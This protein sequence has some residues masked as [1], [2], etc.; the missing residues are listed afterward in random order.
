MPWPFT[1]GE[2]ARND[3][4]A[5]V[6][7]RLAVAGPTF[8]NWRVRA[9]DRPG[10]KLLVAGLELLMAGLELLID[11]HQYQVADV[12]V[13]G[14]GQHIDDRVGHIL[15][16]QAGAGGHAGRHLFVAAYVPKVV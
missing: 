7:P 13:G 3:G 8:L 9:P 16:T 10:P 2:R 12:D 11:G 15:R 6:D 4:P 5:G 14:P 1:P